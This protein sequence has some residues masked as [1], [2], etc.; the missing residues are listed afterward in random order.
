M[1]VYQRVLA[2][3]V[4]IGVAVAL[5][6]AAGTWRAVPAP[7]V[8]VAVDYAAMRSLCK[9]SGPLTAEFATSLRD[10]GVEAFVVRSTSLD[11]LR[12]SGRMSVIAGAELVAG[13]RVFADAPRE[14]PA[15]VRPDCTYVFGATGEERTWLL[16]RLEE[17]FG[18]DRVRCASW[19][20]GWI[21]LRG[22]EGVHECPLG[23]DVVALRE[24]EDEGFRVVPA[25]DE[26]VVAGSDATL[27]LTIEEIS[28]LRSLDVVLLDEPLPR[29]GLQELLTEL[30]QVGARI[31]LP[32]ERSADMA[33]SL[34]SAGGLDIVRSHDVHVWESPPVFSRAARERNVRFFVF[35]PFKT[36]FGPDK[37]IA[38]N[39]S[40]VDDVFTDLEDNGYKAGR[41]AAIP[42]VEAG[43]GLLWALSAC[44]WLGLTRALDRLFCLSPRWA[45]TLGVAGCLAFGPALWA[46]GFVARQAAS[47]AAAVAFPFLAVVA[48]CEAASRA[49][50]DPASWPALR[51]FVIAAVVSVAGGI[52]VS[53][54][55][56]NEL[57]LAGVHGFR[58]VK[59]A[60]SIPVLAVAVYA[61]GSGSAGAPI[62]V[63]I[64]R[65]YRFMGARVVVGAVAVLALMAV[66]ALIYVGR[67]GHGLGIPVALP[68][69]AFRSWLESVLFIRPRFKEFLIGHP[70]LLAGLALLAAG[71]RGPG[72]VAVTVGTIGQVSVVNT[73]AHVHTPL[74]V[75][76]L[77][78]SYG[79]LLGSGGGLALAWVMNSALGRVWK[80]LNG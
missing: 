74:W 67:T 58:G 55:L 10:R 6:V 11:E 65:L 57:C 4:A 20:G 31:V 8:E 79:L 18:Q 25:I 42:R 46:S 44:A 26:A 59:V 3:A 21:E 36:E 75:C 64:K 70:A 38:M 73:F 9:E 51:G 63:F 15:E 32:E 37:T 30:R 12:D 14:L 62:V 17:A 22:G 54:L 33:A 61:F 47:L 56:C 71:R 69:L 19:D 52:V 68:E 78:M 76:A 16:R 35:R 23:F 50:A 53:G 72:L 43:F 40:A 13:A 66:G 27:S 41:P 24:L 49:P 77:R 1:E 29:N 34:S 39:L 60:H 48:A 80:G 28:S 2:A 45:L 7:S 5:V